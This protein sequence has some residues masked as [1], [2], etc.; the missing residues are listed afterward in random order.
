[1]TTLLSRRRLLLASVGVAASAGTA[2]ALAPQAALACEAV[3]KA[4]TAK[5]TGLQRVAALAG[6]NVLSSL[7]DMACPCCGQPLVLF[8]KAV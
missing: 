7:R 6:S 3:H 2:I 4:A 1:M 8:G 5:Y